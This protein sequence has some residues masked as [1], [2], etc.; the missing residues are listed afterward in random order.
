[1]PAGSETVLLVEDEPTVRSI[2]ASALRTAGYSVHEAE[3]GVEALRAITELPKPV[4]LLVTDVIMPRMG[5]RELA[6]Q[7]SLQSKGLRI[8]FISGYMKEDIADDGGT[9]AFL[10]KPF[11]PEQLVRKAREVLDTK[12]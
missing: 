8:L 3:N 2:S 6:Q 1:V 9:V 11:T 5:G 7:L 4:D 10:Q 12:V